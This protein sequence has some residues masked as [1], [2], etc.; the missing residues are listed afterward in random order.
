M[1]FLIMLLE[2]VAKFGSGLS[3]SALLL[4]FIAILVFAFKDIV[5]HRTADGKRMDEI[6]E[7]LSSVASSQEEMKEEYREGFRK[8]NEDLIKQHED[9]Q[10][11][12][13][14][15]REQQFE[16]Q[17]LTLRGLVTNT[18]L[19]D[20]YRMNSYDKYKEL[21]GNSW[22]DKYVDEKLA[23]KTEKQD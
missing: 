14:E 15:L 23:S 3:V 20:E 19:P 4:I 7:K 1:E 21:G 8:I 5:K 6:Q 10:D 2:T 16:N 13:N 11:T 18:S 9:T 12:L 22:L 17:R